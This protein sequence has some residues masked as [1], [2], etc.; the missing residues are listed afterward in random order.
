MGWDRIEY[1]ESAPCAC[2]KGRLIRTTYQEDDDWNRSRFGSFGET[3]ECPEC[4]QKYHIE[5][6]TR[7][8]SQ[9]KWDGDGISD[10]TY[11]VENGYSLQ[12][13]T[14]VAKLSFH[15]LEEEIV[16][17]YTKEEIVQAINDMQTARF[18]TRLQ[19]PS[20]QNIVVLYNRRYK[21]KSL[22]PITVFLNDCVEKYD[23]F[24]W[25][26]VTVK[27]YYENENRLVQ[28]GQIK[29][30]EALQHAKKVEWKRG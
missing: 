22:Q 1:Q 8:Y 19:L 20:S 4:A 17:Q 13:K 16:A 11:L 10:T 9:P 21:K 3:V 7:Y 25:N 5:H 18:S 12:Y 23:T 29:L 6:L 30:K 26:P 14:S 28:E 15:R 27:Q 24:K 2:G